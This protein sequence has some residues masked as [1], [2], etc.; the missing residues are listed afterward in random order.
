MLFSITVTTCSVK[1]VTREHSLTLMLSKQSIEIEIGVIDKKG[2]G[3]EEN[4]KG[5]KNQRINERK[6]DR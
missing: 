6:K 5:S 4:K 2:E 3:G 1:I